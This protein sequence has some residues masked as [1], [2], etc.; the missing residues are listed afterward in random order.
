M[1][2]NDTLIRNSGTTP[3]SSGAPLGHAAIAA[4][5]GSGVAVTYDPSTVPTLIDA[6]V[7]QFVNAVGTS[8]VPAANRWIELT[9]YEDGLLR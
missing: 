7:L 9:D 2:G 4:R 3:G 1:F 6:D 8:F 5:V